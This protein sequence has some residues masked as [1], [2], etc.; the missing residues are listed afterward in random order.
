M[1]DEG[2]IW[3][4][5]QRAGR[6]GHG[7]LSEAW[8][9][10]KAVYIGGWEMGSTVDQLGFDQLSGG[11]EEYI[12]MYSPKW[13]ILCLET[14]TTRSCHLPLYENYSC[15]QFGKHQAESYLLH[16]LS[17]YI[18]WQVSLTQ[19]PT[20]RD[21]ISQNFTLL[22]FVSFNFWELCF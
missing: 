9:L 13:D 14:L 18:W 8:N 4:W 6:I 15:R 22:P 17:R 10:W 16:L 2:L 21:S 20:Y 3:G 5:W 12:Y 1:W 11:H 7:F 19:W